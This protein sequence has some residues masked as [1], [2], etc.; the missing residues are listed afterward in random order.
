MTGN[1]PRTHATLRLARIIS[2]VGHPFLLMPLLTAIAAF[3]LLPASEAIAVELIAL[4]VVIVPSG[5]YTIIRVR[6]GTWNDLDVSDQHQ[7]GQFYAVLLPLLLVVAVISWMSNV[8]R[9]IPL[10]ALGILTL[11]AAAFFLNRWVK[12]SLHTGFGIFAAETLFL[13]RPF[14]GVFVFALALL[15]GWS[16][17]ALGRHVLAEVFFGGL[18]GAIVGIACVFSISFFD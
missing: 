14:W 2:V 10:G 7:R 3:H 12:L 9:A 16:R 5:V 15:V 8:P 17:I 13:F 11:V 6:R 4:G 18:L 1:L